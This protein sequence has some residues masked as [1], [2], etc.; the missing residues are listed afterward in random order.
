MA[1]SLLS[2]TIDSPAF[3]ATSVTSSTLNT[4]GASLLVAVV[5]A[6]AT[7]AP[8]PS[9]T[10]NQ[11]NTYTLA[12]QTT[13]TDGVWMSLYYSSNP[14]T[15]LSHTA[16]FSD[17]S[18]N[19]YWPAISF[20]AYSN[21]LTSSSPLDHTNNNLV[22][23]NSGVLDIQPGAITPGV[24]GELIIAARNDYQ[25]SAGFSVD[26]SFSVLDSDANGLLYVAYLANSGTSAVNPKLS[27]T[28][29]HEAEVG[30]VI[31]SF[32]KA[33]SSITGISSLTGISSITF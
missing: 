10:D 5:H 15:A 6:Q 29:S 2:H 28:T 23:N 4:T 32:K 26:S 12:T 1:I 9:I 30:A 7:A 8:T 31:A 11:S 18:S 22:F 14:I 17:S 21:V 20:S 19:T 3:G 13:Y 16:T 25:G 33:P 27:V 24:S